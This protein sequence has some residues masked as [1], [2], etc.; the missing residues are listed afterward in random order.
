MNRMNI[1]DLDYAHSTIYEKLH[2]YANLSLA[3]KRFVS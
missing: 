3:I 1:S 2:K